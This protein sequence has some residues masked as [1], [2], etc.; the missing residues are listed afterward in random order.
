MSKTTFIQVLAALSSIG[1]TSLADAFEQ[2]SH[3]WI[4]IQAFEK[5]L[6]LPNHLPQDAP[7]DAFY[8]WVE[9]LR[10]AVMFADEVRGPGRNFLGVYDA[11]Q[12]F[13]G[14]TGIASNTG[15]QIIE[16]IIEEDDVSG[17]FR[18]GYMDDPIRVLNH[19]WLPDS[20]HS[21]GLLDFH[22]ALQKAQLLWREAVKEY[23]REGGDRARAFW[24][25]GRVAHLLTDM[26]SPA[27]VHLDQ[28]TSEDSFEHWLNFREN[29]LRIGWNASG[30]D[31]PQP[32]TLP[33]PPYSIPQCYDIQLVKLFYSLASFAR[34]YDSDDS[35]YLLNAAST[36]QNGRYNSFTARVPV[37]LLAIEAP[38]VYMGAPFNRVLKP[39][40]DFEWDDRT[41]HVYFYNAIAIRMA[42]GDTTIRITPPRQSEAFYNVW[43]TSS[44]FSTV[45]GSVLYREH[46]PALVAAAI[47]HTAAL[48]LR[49]QE[50]TRV[51]SI[52][53]RNSVSMRFDASGALGTG[54]GA[55]GGDGG[56]LGVYFGHHIFTGDGR[57]GDLSAS[58]NLAAG[59]YYFRQVYDPC[60][61]LELRIEGDVTIY[62]QHIF[63]PNVIVGVPSTETPSRLTVF[64]GDWKQIYE[65]PGTL[66]GARAALRTVNI[67]IDMD[68]VKPV[69]LGPGGDGGRFHYYCREPAILAVTANVNGGPGTRGNVLPGGR[70]GNGGII[71][72]HTADGLAG[73]SIYAQGGYG[74]MAEGSH[75]G[76]GG[77]GGSI[78][79]NAFLS[80]RLEIYTSGGSGGSVLS[81]T[82][83]LIGGA[84][85]SGGVASIA[86]DG[87]SDQDVASLLK[88]NFGGGF[89]GNGG[90]S[91][92]RGGDAGLIGI[93][94]RTD[95]V[96]AEPGAGGRPGSGGGEAGSVGATVDVS[97]LPEIE[98]HSCS[99]D[100]GPTTVVSI[101]RIERI[102]PTSV[103]LTI[104]EN[105]ENSYRVIEWSDD[106]RNWHSL[107]NALGQSGIHGFIDTELTGFR[108]KYYRVG[109]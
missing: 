24:L 6:Q 7:C 31:I 46:M 32:E 2:R 103:R 68:G 101:S 75:A 5:V 106:L 64:A 63:G 14:M 37:P 94:D 8:P 36:V 69:T 55:F 82:P 52:E 107:G 45:P 57:H 92:G 77:K 51:R 98:P 93:D 95:L 3:R 13:S 34:R 83:Q 47:D 96:T 105:A 26:A 27:H 90:G 97:F 78:T 17:V 61:Q 4:A 12:I 43:E 54:D 76:N 23:T 21:D 84:G 39:G 62:C 81:N 48:F 33:L 72:L 89:G 85:G 41:G 104:D 66:T 99:T 70:G 42:L 22:S 65:S 74:G 88:G 102:S 79:I 19:F 9:R 87:S 58:T 73:G 35:G 91:G 15:T 44:R 53:I 108:G 40:E 20:N 49:F 18:P 80:N 100:Q 30:S 86:I 56:E 50:V 38:L 1:S 25:L 67:R 28:H 71:N 59:T 60:A 16:G 11:D 10:P 29:H 109:E